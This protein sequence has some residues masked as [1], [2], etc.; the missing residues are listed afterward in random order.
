MKSFAR[1]ALIS[2]LVLVPVGV[3]VAMVDRGRGSRA[4]L[5]EVPIL[6][7]PFWLLLCLW[8]TLDPR[9]FLGEVVAPVLPF[10]RRE[11]FGLLLGLLNTIASVVALYL[12]SN[13]AQ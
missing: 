4:V 9:R 6:F 1:A 3:L 5:Q 13:S 11:V 8:I 7:W 2:L 10:G 12:L